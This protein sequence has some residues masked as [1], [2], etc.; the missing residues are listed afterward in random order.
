MLQVDTP[1]ALDGYLAELSTTLSASTP[2]DPVAV[3]AIMERHDT[4]RVPATG[5]ERSRPRRSDVSRDDQ[6]PPEPSIGVVLETEDLRLEFVV[7]RTESDG[8]LHQMR[9]TYGPHSAAPPPHLHPAQDETF[10]IVDG[11]VEFVLDG[12][13]TRH[14]APSMV[15]IRA[16]TVHQLHNPADRSAT[17]VWSTRPALRTGEF[18][19]AMHDAQRSGDTACLV[20]VLDEYDDVFCLAA[21]PT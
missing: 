5:I 14:R 9:A 2:P 7:T 16:G 4:H 12:V 21:H 1:Q 13:T 19:M 15:T 17:V 10:E 20:A 3:A 11:V 6:S 18:F 8:D